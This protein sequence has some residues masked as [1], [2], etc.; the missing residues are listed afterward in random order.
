VYVK[1]DYIKVTLNGAVILEGDLKKAA[2]NG[3]L[4]KKGHPG[5]KRRSGHIAF[6]G[7]GSVVKFRNLRIQDLSKK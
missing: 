7:H 3:T 5:L 4:D 1:G 2:K 6:L